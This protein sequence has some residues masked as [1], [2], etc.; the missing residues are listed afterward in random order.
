MSLDLE[1][2]ASEMWTAGA[3]AL[4]RQGAQEAGY[5][6]DEFKKIAQTIATIEAEVAAKQIDQ[7][8]AAVLLDMQASASRSVLLTAKGVAAVVAQTAI[9]AALAA[10][11]GTVNKALG[12][13][14]ILL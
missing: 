4:H 2:I 14:L 5:M 11:A 1:Q 7:D 10:V 12:F 9:N 3:S 6:R 8:M 13:S